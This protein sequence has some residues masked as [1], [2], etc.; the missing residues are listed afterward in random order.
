MIPPSPTTLITV[1]YS[2][3]RVDEDFPYEFDVLGCVVCVKHDPQLEDQFKLVIDGV[4]FECLMG[5]AEGRDDAI[6]I[7]SSISSYIDP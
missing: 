4:S 7:S 5:I 2:L 1:G 6:S 3:H